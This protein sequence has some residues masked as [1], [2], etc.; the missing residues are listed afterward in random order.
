MTT[1]S[2]WLIAG[3]AISAGALAALAVGG[4]LKAQETGILEPV[5]ALHCTAR[6][7]EGAATTK[8]RCNLRLSDARDD[9]GTF[10]GEMFGEGLYLVAPGEISVVWNVFAPGPI[11]ASSLAGDYDTVSKHRFKY[12]QENRNL[13]IGG[14][15]DVVAL[16]LIAP[17]VDPITPATRLTL[18]EA[19]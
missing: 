17:R 12:E 5:G 8:L 15:N 3:A 7:A 4:D 19:G 18:R 1:F 11:Q 16:E 9:R 14:R 10:E 6:R 2:T 13:L